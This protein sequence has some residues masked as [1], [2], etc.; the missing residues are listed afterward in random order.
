[1]FR[2]LQ[3][4]FQKNPEKT[5]YKMHKVLSEILVVLTIQ[6]Q[7]VL[8]CGQSIFR[9]QDIVEFYGKQ[10]RTHRSAELHNHRSH[11]YK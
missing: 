11:L 1:M 10:F 2:E 5:F 6:N 4:F 3:G 8:M 7:A 9:A